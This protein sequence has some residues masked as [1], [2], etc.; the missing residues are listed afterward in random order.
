MNR[1][2]NTKQWALGSAWKKGKTP[3]LLHEMSGV[4][5]GFH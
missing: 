4:L 2:K 5:S 3:L 1:I